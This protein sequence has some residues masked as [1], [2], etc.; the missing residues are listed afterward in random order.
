MAERRQGAAAR[1]RQSE[2]PCRMLEA[3]LY[4]TCCRRSK[5]GGS[6]SHTLKDRVYKP[7]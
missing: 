5:D 2:T 1:R 6:D 4:Y 7:E 3:C